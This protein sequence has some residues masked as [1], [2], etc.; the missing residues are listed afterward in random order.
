MNRSSM[1]AR[2][3]NSCFRWSCPLVSPS[4]RSSAGQPRG[5]LCESLESRNLLAADFAGAGMLDPIFDP[6]A[7]SPEAFVA[8]EVGTLEAQLTVAGEEGL[9]QDEHDGE[10][11]EAI[12]KLITDLRTLRE[13]SEITPEQI[14][15]LKADVQAVFDAAEPP[16][17]ELVDAFKE[18]LSDALQDGKLTLPEVV[19]LSLS[20]KDVI[21]SAKIPVEETKVVLEDLKGIVEASNVDRED[22]ALIVDDLQAIGE[23]LPNRWIQP[24]GELQDAVQQ[25]ATDLQTLREESEV[26]PEQIEQLKA[27]VQA[28][29]D[30]AQPPDP[31][32]VMAFQGELNDALEDGKLSLSET[33][34]L[35][36]SLNEVLES[37]GIPAE[38][39]QAVVGDLRAIVE[40]SNI[41]RDDLELIAED[42]RAIR[43]AL[44][45]RR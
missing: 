17:P 21:R 7:E 27:D 28:V 36:A 15:Q 11:L 6:A 14:E 41:E 8:A 18:E 22:I 35:M 33:L 31:E 32:L 4:A 37:A 5:L 38:E 45:G 24:D 2:F 39:L 9:Q 34:A 16:D 25:L 40:A 3:W 29:L 20:L 19:D 13:E 23:A 30:G 26:T 10:L 12:E 42:L 44:P 43:E 1:L